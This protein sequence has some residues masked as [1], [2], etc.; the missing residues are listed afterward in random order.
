MTGQSISCTAII[1]IYI[2][3]APPSLSVNS[4][5]KVVNEKEEEAI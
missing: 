3:Q 4:S 1:A 5:V 2:L